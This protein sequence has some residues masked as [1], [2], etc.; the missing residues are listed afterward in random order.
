MNQNI[1]NSKKRYEKKKFKHLFVQ[2]N[3]SCHICQSHCNTVFPSQFV[4]KIF[5]CSALISVIG[6]PSGGSLHCG[7]CEGMLGG[8]VSGWW[9][10]W[11]T[12]HAPERFDQVGCSE[13]VV[14]LHS[15]QNSLSTPVLP[16]STT[17]T[18]PAEEGERITIEYLYMYIYIYLY[19]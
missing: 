17:G 8:Q 14:T 19:I 15:G 10:R 16:C 3:N 11:D 4:K 13:E 12:W 2:L 9:L 5:T 7:C 18:G 1:D 6:G